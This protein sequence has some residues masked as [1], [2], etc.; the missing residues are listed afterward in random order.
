MRL[1]LSLW[2]LIVLIREETDKCFRTKMADSTTSILNASFQ[3]YVAFLSSIRDRCRNGLPFDLKVQ[4]T[5]ASLNDNQHQGA[6]SSRKVEASASPKMEGTWVIEG[7]FVLST[8]ERNALLNDIAK[9]G[10]LSPATHVVVSPKGTVPVPETFRRKCIDAVT[11][12]VA[13]AFGGLIPKSLSSTTSIINDFDLQKENLLQLSPVV[14]EPPVS[15]IS[16]E[17]QKCSFEWKV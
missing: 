9:H 5:A 8:K 14:V 13:Q 6:A 4:G 12:E 17:F 16:F 3:R 1:I 15:S 2:V 10:K 7:K 11:P